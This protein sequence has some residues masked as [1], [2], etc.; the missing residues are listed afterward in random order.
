MANDKEIDD[1]ESKVE[2]LKVVDGDVP[3]SKAALKKLEKNLEKEKRKQE[4]ALRLENERL[5]RQSEVVDYSTERYGK[6]TMNQSKTRENL[7]FTKIEDL[8]NH[9][10]QTVLLTARVQ[11][12]RTTGVK[13]LFLTLR[14]QTVTAQSILVHDKDQISK[15]MMKFASSI[16]SESLVRVEAV[17]TK[18]PELI[19]SCTVQEYELKIVK[20]HVISEAARLPFSLEDAMRP[21]LEGFSAVLLDTRLNNRVVDLRTTT[22]HAIFRIQAAV[23]RLF[24]GYLDNMGF[25]EIHTPKLISAASEGG[26]NVFKVSYFKENAFLAQSP[27]LYK[28]MMI[29]ADFDRVYEIAPVFRAENSLT[30]RHM[31]EFMGLDMEMAFQ[32]HYHE[33]LD[34]LGHLF[35]HIF[36]G[37]KTLNKS[38]IEVVN[39]QYPFEE[40]KYL[41]QSLV[42][43]FKEGV[44]MLRDA[45][46]EVGDFDDFTTENERILGRLVREK[47]QTDFYILDKFP[48]A[49]R[50]FYTMPDPNNPV[51]ISLT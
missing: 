34:T 32:E 20:V 8:G 44:K 15:Q 26:A 18:A 3:L 31:T 48:L 30:H 4:V 13:I 45:G 27:Q 5:L 25:I 42:L 11:N 21:T 35:V 6:L 39:S 49:I 38:D 10:G 22:N 41:P 28:Q 9:V 50:P 36:D 33:V 29:C 17:V 7:T 1:V 47:Y 37:L 12:S 14:Q 43:Q 19:K 51:M 40:F 46:V 23:G 2:G 16:T 24:R